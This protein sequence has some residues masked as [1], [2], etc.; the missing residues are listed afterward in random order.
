M[1][2]QP[3]PQNEKFLLPSTCRPRELCDG[4]TVEASKSSRGTR[5]L[6]KQESR[7]TSASRRP[8]CNENV[9]GGQIK[10]T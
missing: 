3:S 4:N 5:Q 9:P 2:R 10:A 8:L 6:R 7:P 1:V